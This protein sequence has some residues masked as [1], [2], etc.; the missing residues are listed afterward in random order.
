MKPILVDK[1]PRLCLFAVKFI[2]SGVEL[3]YVF[4]LFFNC[5][6]NLSKGKYSVI[7]TLIFIGLTRTK[8][9]KIMCV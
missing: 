5:T 7:Y 2:P 8:I 6:N 4:F 1:S 9:Y 3:R